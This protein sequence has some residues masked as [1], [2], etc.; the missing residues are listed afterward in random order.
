M[1]KLITPDDEVDDDVGVEGNVGV[2]D[3]VGVEDNV[4]YD[5]Q[6]GGRHDHL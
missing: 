5:G 1:A 2:D 6:H 4:V 3:D